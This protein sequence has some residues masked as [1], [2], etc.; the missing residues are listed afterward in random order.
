MLVA[1]IHVKDEHCTA[2]SHIFSQ[3]VTTPHHKPHDM[4]VLLLIVSAGCL[5][6]P[7]CMSLMIV[8]EN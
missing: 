7:H 8:A 4:K 1:L 5:F 2:E 6:H 3:L